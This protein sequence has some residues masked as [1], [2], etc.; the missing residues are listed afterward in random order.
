[1]INLFMMLA[2]NS[3][4]VLPQS[5]GEPVSSA[6]GTV[7]QTLQSPYTLSDPLSIMLWVVAV[8]AIIGIL[9]TLTDRPYKFRNYKRVGPFTRLHDV[10]TRKYYL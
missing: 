4:N 8:A 5:N 1:M 9:W 2:G 10:L 7:A 3:A 6:A